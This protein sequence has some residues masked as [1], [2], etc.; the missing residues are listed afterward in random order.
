[1]CKNCQIHQNSS[2]GQQGGNFCFIKLRWASVNL[3]KLISCIEKIDS[4]HLV[5]FFFSFLAL[6]FHIQMYNC[7]VSLTNIPPVDLHLI[8]EISSLR[9]WFFNLICG[10]D[11]LSISSL[12]LT[13]CAACK[14]TVQNRQK[15]KFKNQVRKLEISKIQSYVIK[16]A[17]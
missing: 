5:V 10:L 2:T 6:T 17:P 13:A 7:F 15:L 3:H 11:F 12:I 14:D 8:F 1:M 16:S 4:N 9:N